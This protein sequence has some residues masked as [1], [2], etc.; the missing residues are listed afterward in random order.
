MSSNPTMLKSLLI[1]YAILPALVLLLAS[2]TRADDLPRKRPTMDFGWK[3]LL[4]DP[5]G[6]QQIDF[7]DSAWQSVDLP[8]DWSIFGPFD[9]NAPAEGRGAYL[10]TGVGWYRKSF[11]LPDSFKSRQIR[12][13]FDGVYQNSDVWINNHHLGKRP[14]GY[15]SFGYDLTPYLSFT[16]P[17]VLAV[18]VDNS[19]QPNS[20]WY[21]GSGIYRH[22][23]LTMTDPLSIE[24]N[25]IFVTTPQATQDSG[26]IEVATRVANHRPSR[27]H[28]TI[29]STLL[30]RDGHE[31][32]AARSDAELDVGESGKIQQEIRVDHPILWSDESPY[33]YT[34]RTQVLSRE[35][36]GLSS[37][38]DRANIPNQSPGS[39]LP[40]EIVVDT[41]NTPIGIRSIEF[42]VDRGLLLNGK[43]V[44][45][46]GVCLHHDGGSV[47]A[48]VPEGVWIRRLKLLKEMGCNA[49]RT[50]HNPPAPEFLDLCDQMGFLVMDEAFDEWTVGKT[51]GGYHRFFSDWSQRDLVDF[52]HRDRNHPSVILWSAGNEIPEQT[53]PGGADVLR[54]LV[55]T[56]HREDPTRLVTAACDKAFAE[57]L[58]APPE[59]MALLDVAGYNYVDRWLDRPNTFYSTDRHDFPSRRFIGTESVSMGGIRGDYR[60]LF[61]NPAAATEP[62]PLTTQP[63]SPQLGARTATGGTPPSAAPEAQ[64][65][66]VAR[67]ATGGTPPSAEPEAQHTSGARTATGG[68]PPSAQPEAQHTPVRRRFRFLFPTNRRLDVEQL[69]SF[70]RTYDYVSGDF[71]WT[72]IDY[73]GEAFWPAR[74]GFFGVIDTCGFPKDGYYFYQS[75]WTTKPMIHL[76][77]H[78]N[79]PGHEGQVIPVSC[80]TNCD[81]VELLVNGRSFGVKGYEFPRQGMHE[82]YGTYPARA[83]EIRTTSDLHLSWDV[84][85]AP[86]KIEAVGRS[87]GKVV[88]NEQIA[89]TGE[90]AA[91]VLSPDKTTLAAD[92][93]DVVHLA[94]SIVDSNGLP[95][96]TAS[97]EVTFETDGPV[98]LI[99]VDNGDPNNHD[100]FKSNRCKAF[101]GLCLAIVQSTADPGTIHIRAKADGLRE[102]SIGLTAQP[103]TPE[104]SIP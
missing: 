21:S 104:L 98:R 93:R 9:E 97:N 55:E 70:V 99:G 18:R 28:F 88:A 67:R 23:W 24:P 86:G 80:Y 103:A 4:G 10:P 101:N 54:P 87:N 59:F 85:Y 20:R 14:F 29:I 25:G 37:A 56:F 7:N 15:I 83:R 44:K 63:D 73:L 51:A 12:I 57:P 53:L 40:G 6:A 72:G 47:G 100:S 50:S 17:N 33:L 22:T 2:R 11:R 94:V 64:H 76:F 31:V 46:N 1:L 13:E 66:S 27:E 79:W 16:S 45:L 32:K 74:S 61:P 82:D 38:R 62:A 84:P 69:W 58:S 35:G 5:A 26:T 43:H 8:H 36:D 30:D 65:M 96:P 75:Q 41:V 77:P 52:I 78:W 42:N 19:F 81:T 49:I 48:A 39:L 95:V 71:M 3:F 102:A 89:T 92:R 91:I 90:P 60:D 68:T 34:L